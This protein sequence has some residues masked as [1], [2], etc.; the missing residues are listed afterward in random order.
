MKRNLLLV[1]LFLIVTAV[2]GLAQVSFNYKTVG[3][4]LLRDEGITEL[5]SN[6]QLTVNSI[7]GA[8][9]TVP[10]G[11]GISL[12]F[13]TAET[14]TPLTTGFAGANVDCETTPGTFCPITATLTKTT[15]AGDTVLI[16]FTAATTFTLTGF[17]NINNLRVNASLLPAGTPVSGTVSGSVGSNVN[18]NLTSQLVGTV[19]S[20]KSLAVGAAS[21][22]GA[23]PVMLSILTCAP[24]VA[25]GFETLAIDV[26]EAFPSALRVLADEGFG[27]NATDIIS[28]S[29]SNVP[30]N[31]TITP[32]APLICAQP[33]S[34][35][36]AT[37]VLTLSTPAAQTSSA[38]AMTLTFTY[39]V[40]T[41]SLSVLE[42]AELDFDVNTTL[43]TLPVNQATPS[44]ATVVLGPTSPSTSIPLFSGVAEPT[45]QNIIAW[46]DCV[47]DILLPYVTNFTGT[48]TAPDSFYNTGITI[49]NTSSDLAGSTGTSIFASGGALA[50]AGSC[51][52]WL[53]PASGAPSIAYTTPVIPAGGQL[54][55][56]QGSVPGW[57]GLT[58]Y[59]IGTC[60]FQNAHTF[61]SV[62]D[63]AGLGSPTFQQGGLGLILPNPS[64][65][66]RSPAG[67]GAGE[68]LVF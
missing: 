27:A 17:I 30:L 3:P 6:L 36:P 25:P 44:V 11:A 45:P 2:P 59:I 56:T 39:T 58:G 68:G 18:F 52:L 1:G 55:I 37:C 16:S 61:V 60:H 22:T 32:L 21:R 4:T 53:F 31:V 62:Y 57:A 12:V 51:T 66:K 64:I 38:A 34:S 14:V 42:D 35:P 49:A 63:N 46:A 9:A 13:S 54:G 5:I 67:G 15:V 8:G 50:Q 65:V 33:S 47:T 26:A 43:T 29:I 19:S 10:T 23:P 24:P 41:E 7:G 48:G 40:L 20:V 28:V